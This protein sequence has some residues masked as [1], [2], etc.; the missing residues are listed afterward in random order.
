MDFELTNAPRRFFYELTQIPHGSYNE[1]AVS[2]WL[3]RFAKERGLNYVQD[4]MW[5]VV[6]YKPGSAGCEDSAP[7]RLR[8]K[9]GDGARF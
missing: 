7:L 2:D 1:K 5:N 9:Q 6:I 4:D 3:V 8:G